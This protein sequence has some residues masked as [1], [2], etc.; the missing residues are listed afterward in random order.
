MTPAGPAAPEL[1]GPWRGS[2]PPPIL[3]GMGVTVTYLLAVLACGLVL[4]STR[5]PRGARP[6]GRGAAVGR[7]AM[8]AAWLYGGGGLAVLFW[9]TH[10]RTALGVVLTVVIAGLALRYGPGRSSPGPEPGADQD[11]G[12]GGGEPRRPSP[13]PGPAGGPALDWREF[14]D[15]R[16][17]WERPRVGV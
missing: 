14:D 11:G 10:P 7:A 9:E 13:S 15:A 12:G 3:E 17:T 6:P 8:W 1:G 2:G 5:P 4:S 16:R